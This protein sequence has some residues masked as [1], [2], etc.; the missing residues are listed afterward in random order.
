M[1]PLPELRIAQFTDL[2][3]VD[4]SEN[5]EEFSLL[6]TSIGSSISEWNVDAVLLT[7]DLTQRG[8][9]DSLPILSEY[10][11]QLPVPAI[12]AFGNHDKREVFLKSF[13]DP[14]NQ[15]PEDRGIA[16]YAGVWDLGSTDIFVLDSN[17]DDDGNGNL[18]PVQLEW[19]SQQLKISTASDSI[20]VVHHPVLSSPLRTLERPVFLGLEDL[21]R[22]LLGSTVRVI[23]S[24]HYHHSGATVRNGILGWSGPAF[25]WETDLSADSG[26]RRLD[27][28]A[29]SLIRLHDH[30]PSCVPIPIGNNK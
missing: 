21:D 27:H 10:L 28:R 15:A 12:P 26:S 19:L 8:F 29:W 30:I 1:S 17:V 14:P 20:V 23:L 7:G 24:G 5:S 25:C 11:S 6:K 4:L 9:S 13:P 22:V 18:S 3:L 16:P 2:H